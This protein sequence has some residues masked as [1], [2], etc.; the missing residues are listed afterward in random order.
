VCFDKHAEGHRS[1]AGDAE[2]HLETDGSAGRPKRAAGRP[3]R[4]DDS[5]LVLE[6]DEA[7]P[8]CSV[9]QAKFRCSTQSG[10]VF[11]NLW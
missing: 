10:S 11:K 2:R 3:R 1:K 5:V 6:A 4:F 7:T 9:C 8:E